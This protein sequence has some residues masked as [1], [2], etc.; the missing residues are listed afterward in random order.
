MEY[1]MLVRLSLH[2]AGVMELC[3]RY[4]CNKKSAGLSS[5]VRLCHLLQ[6]CTLH[7]HTPRKIAS[8]DLQAC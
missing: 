1:R 7:L 2:L 4:Q 3:K 5:F 6:M 8:A